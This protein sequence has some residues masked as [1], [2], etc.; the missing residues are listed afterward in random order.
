VT[1]DDASLKY[2]NKELLKMYLTW[3]KFE[4]KELTRLKDKHSKTLLNK[5]KQPNDDA[6]KYLDKKAASTSSK[7]QDKAL[8]PP[9]PYIKRTWWLLS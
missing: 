9:S 8:P 3:T 4:A 5:S 6:T 2:K 7:F 1:I